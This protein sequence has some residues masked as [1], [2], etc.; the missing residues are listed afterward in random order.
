LIILL[1]VIVKD[2]DPKRM[3]INLTG[4]L[5]SKTQSF[6]TELWNLLLS[7]QNS[8]GGIPTEFI[9]QK[10]QELRRKQTQE[11]ERRAQRDS[12]MDTIRQKKT[13]EFDAL[14]EARKR[15]S[16]FVSLVS[17]QYHEKLLI[18]Y[19]YYR[20][21]E[22]IIV[23]IV[24][25]NI[26]DLLLAVDTDLD[27]DHLLVKIDVVADII[28]VMIIIAAVVVEN[29]MGT[30]IEE[31]EE[32]E[33]AEIVEVEVQITDQIKNA[34]LIFINDPLPTGLFMKLFQDFF[35][36]CTSLNIWF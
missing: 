10:K 25:E 34:K 27:L 3:Q 1:N 14:Q 35:L 15:S 24:I 18:K 23:A 12:V 30:D 16:R 21:I 22:V 7:A 17:I 13:D 19:I 31:A 20:M 36:F 26:V 29:V 5:E 6:L 32:E 2:Q 8:V 9:E 4:F 11:D 28:I 33:I